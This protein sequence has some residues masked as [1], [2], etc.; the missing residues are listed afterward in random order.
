MSMALF[1]IV[2]LVRYKKAWFDNKVHGS[3]EKALFDTKM[4]GST[5]KCPTQHASVHIAIIKHTPCSLL[6]LCYK[7]IQT[8]CFKNPIH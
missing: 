6:K 7:F 2:T 4:S 5:Q 3:T 1:V 8:F